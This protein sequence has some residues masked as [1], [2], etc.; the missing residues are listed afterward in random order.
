MIMF[1]LRSKSDGAGGEDAFLWLEKGE[2]SFI[3]P[4][5]TLL[6]KDVRIHRFDSSSSHLSAFLYI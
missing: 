4:L 6:V 5:L 2:G 3:S 1:F